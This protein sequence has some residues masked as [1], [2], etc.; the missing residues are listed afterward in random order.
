VKCLINYNPSRKTFTHSQQ[1]QDFF[2]RGW[3]GVNDGCVKWVTQVGGPVVE[4]TLA[5]GSS[6]DC[7]A[8]EAHHGK[9]CVLDLC[10]LKSGFL[11]WV[12]GQTKRVE[13][14]APWVQPLFWVK[15]WVPLEL[16]VPN[17]QNLDPNQCGDWEWKWLP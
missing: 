4:W 17:Y 11:L 16:Y 5:S 6:L 13:V 1:V 2:L 14:A 15:L 8:Q 10:Q 3:E 12:R 9:T 7:K